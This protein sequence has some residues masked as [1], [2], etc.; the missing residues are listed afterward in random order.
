M[1]EVEMIL[2]IFHG[3]GTKDLEQHCFIYETIW[4]E[5]YDTKLAQLAATFRDRTLTWY[6]ELQASTPIG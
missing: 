2:P 1:E 4:I 3:I 6:M 5:G